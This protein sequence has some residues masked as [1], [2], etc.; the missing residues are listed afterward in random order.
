MTELYQVHLAKFEGP[1][2]LLLFFIERD[3]LDIYDIPI[4]AITHDFID[5]LHK[6]EKEQ[7][8]IAADFLVMAAR[9]MRIKAQM[10]LPRPI[11]NEIGEIVD[12]RTELVENLLEFK[13]YKE[14]IN[15]FQELE[16]LRSQLISRGFVA[17][18]A[19]LVLHQFEPKDELIG[20]NLY[21]LLRVYKQ[22]ITARA[23]QARKPRHVI[24]RYPYDIDE[25]KVLV[26]Q[27]AIESEKTTF[28][29]VISI[30]PNRIFMVFVLMA[31]LELVQ[32][33]KLRTVV[34]TYNDIEIYPVLP[35]M[36]ETKPAVITEKEVL[37]IE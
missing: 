6:L 23:I 34:H 28:T 30:H 13:K 3:E 37:V 24:E 33:K 26:Q 5:Y 29:E 7:L 22:V 27:M 12:P 36:L 21:Q 17:Q 10:L 35:S 19:Q 11:I 8:E 9:L 2:D 25:V 14:I 32:E 1:F 20:L 16:Q 31:V 4:A 15:S 18:E